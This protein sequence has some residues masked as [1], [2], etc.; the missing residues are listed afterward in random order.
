MQGR[1]TAPSSWRTATTLHGATTTRSRTRATAWGGA[2]KR[3][4][5][6]SGPSTGS[7]ATAMRW[8]PMGCSSASLTGAGGASRGSPATCTCRHLLR[9]TRSCRTWPR[10]SGVRWRMPADRWWRHKTRQ[11][12]PTACSRPPM[13]STACSHTRAA[14]DP[15]RR[16][17]ALSGGTTLRT[18]TRRSSRCSRIPTWSRGTAWRRSRSRRWGSRHAAWR[19]AWRSGCSTAN[20]AK[21][22]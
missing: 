9:P 8:T 4:R 2:S 1:G 21:A 10:F 18:T 3:P 14:L 16:A 11:T 6:T 22:R 13:S 5:S 7:G 12:R 15:S 17:H 19:C 20:R